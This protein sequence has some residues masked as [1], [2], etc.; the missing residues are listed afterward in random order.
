MAD[1]E[2]PKVGEKAP[3]FELPVFPGGK[4]LKLSQFRSKKN[5]VLYF[6]PKDDTPGCT[7]QACGFRDTL[8][9]LELADTVVLGVSGDSLK[10][11]EKFAAKHSLPF[12][13]LA[14]EN[15]EVCQKYGV[16]VEKSMYGKKS[17]GIVRTTFLIDKTGTIVKVW[18]KV[19]VDDHMKEVKAALSELGND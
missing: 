11:H 10:S 5:V 9:H 14:D 2:M 7:K 18:P 12:P 3:S 4:K 13:L 17:M 1:S 6:Y 8:P 15:H 16:W 19:K